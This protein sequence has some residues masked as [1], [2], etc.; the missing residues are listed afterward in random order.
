MS[1]PSTIAALILAGGTADDEFC[2]AS[3]VSIRALAPFRT[4]TMLEHVVKALSDRSIVPLIEQIV[5]M[6]DVPETSGYTV[7]S[8]TGTFTGNLST[9]LSELL[10]FDLA[11]VSTADIPFMTADTVLSFLNEALVLMEE[12]DT[13]MI[14]PVVPVNLCYEQFPGIKRTAIKLREGALTGGNIGLVRPRLLLN[15]LPAIA[16]AFDARKSPIKL[17]GILGPAVIARLILS[18]VAA[19]SLLDTTFLEKSVSR[20]IGGRARSIVCRLPELATDIDRASDYI[21][22]T[23]AL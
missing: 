12:Q 21:A 1:N 11:L 18:Q 20:L 2:K 4:S 3:G 15:C 8:D 10:S 19:P 5:V 22:V 23:R 7:I 9:G 13:A 17:A 6:G 16:R 14:W